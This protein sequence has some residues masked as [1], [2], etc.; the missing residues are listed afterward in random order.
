M[1]LPAI[2]CYCFLV[3]VSVFISM[4]LC[5]YEINDHHHGRAV[6]W[7]EDGE[8]M[9][10]RNNLV[11]LRRRNPVS[12]TVWGAYLYIVFGSWY[13]SKVPWITGITWTS[14]VETCSVHWQHLCGS[15]DTIRIPA[16]QRSSNTSRND[17]RWLNAPV[18]QHGMMT[19]GS[20]L[21]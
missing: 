6:L 3:Y 12:V 17:D 15:G 2:T 21:Q 4:S 13:S 7:R 5:D 19:G 10:P 9:D 11:C 18:T 1:W 20:T 14:W 16:G 8:T